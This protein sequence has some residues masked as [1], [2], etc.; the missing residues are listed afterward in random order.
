MK[1]SLHEDLISSLMCV[2]AFGWLIAYCKV[3]LNWT[4]MSELEPSK[5]KL[6]YVSK[7][8]VG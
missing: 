7:R 1:V 4:T 8:L 5:D 6:D 2:S 3:L